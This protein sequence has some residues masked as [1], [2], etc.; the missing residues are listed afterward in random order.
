MTI[1][2][3]IESSSDEPLFGLDRSK[4]I[5]RPVPTEPCPTVEELKTD[6]EMATLEIAELRTRLAAL[7][8][9]E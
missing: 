8:D 1:D 4:G 7:E 2:K 6:L 9:V 5:R 3:W